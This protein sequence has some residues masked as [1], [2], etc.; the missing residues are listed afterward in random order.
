LGSEDSENRP[1]ALEDVLVEEA[2]S[3]VANTH[4][5]G[6]P[7]INLFTMEETVLK[8]LLTNE[9][10]RLAVELD[11]HAQGVCIGLLPAF[12]LAVKMEGL[13]HSVMPLCLHDTSPFSIRMDP[14]SR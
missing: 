9:I 3:A 8:L 11:E 2:Y 6:G 13:D 1:V 7:L 10:G 5:I 4:C 12:V 14:P